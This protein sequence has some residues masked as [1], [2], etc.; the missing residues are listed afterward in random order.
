MPLQRQPTHYH[1][2]P[3]SRAGD[4]GRSGPG[5][6][7]IRLALSVTE[8]AYAIGCSRAWLY[9][10]GLQT[11]ELASI[12]LG[13]RVVIPVAA[14]GAF[15]RARLVDPDDTMPDLLDIALVASSVPEDEAVCRECGSSIARE[16]WHAASIVGAADGDDQDATVRAHAAHRG[17]ATARVS[18]HGLHT[19]RTLK[20]DR[21]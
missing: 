3:R 21:Q 4:V 14:L 18:G 12:H 7:N 11:G 9:R 17:R 16:T 5:P 19:T 8:A 13:R 2:V 15:L 6:G 20:R 1:A 10:W